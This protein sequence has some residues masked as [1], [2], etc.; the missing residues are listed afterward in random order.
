MSVFFVY[1]SQYETPVLNQLKIFSDATVFD[2]FKR[3][4]KGAESYD[5]S[6]KI[7]RELI[8]I[9]VYGFDSIFEAIGEHQIGSPEDE[10]ALARILEKHL[11]VEG[12]LKFEPHC[13]QVLTDDDELDV[14]YYI[15]D[16]I[17][18]EQ[19]R[20]KADF[21]LARDFELST[22]FENDSAQ[23]SLCVDAELNLIETTG[24]GEGLLFFASLSEY[25]SGGNLSEIDGG[26]VIKGLRL[27]DLPEFLASVLPAQGE[28]G[29]A[30]S[31]LLLLRSQLFSSG[32]YGTDA[33]PIN[34]EHSEK[35]LETP[36]NRKAWQTFF[37]E[38]IDPAEAKIDILEKALVACAQFPVVFLGYEYDWN[39]N[40]GKLISVSKEEVWERLRFDHE[41]RN[42]PSKMKLQVD[43]HFAQV[44]IHTDRWNN[45]LDLY[46][47]WIFFDDLW[48]AKNPNLANSILRYATRWDMLSP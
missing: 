19:N 7:A 24:S 2:W 21:L 33:P 28:I 9:D 47:R 40:S 16:D 30:P 13:I 11:Y 26:W 32:C 43:E 5:E 34:Q 23:E 42:D 35:L 25:G 46:N 39:F 1:R 10:Q 38:H 4:W 31:E 45:A 44:S 37:S 36:T 18:L 15:F 3:N 8:G 29:Y 14:A 12:E 41:P 48:A 6:T 20:D 22:N 27:P 17:F